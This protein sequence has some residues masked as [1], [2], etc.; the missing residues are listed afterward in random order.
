MWN[1]VLHV[2]PLIQEMYSIMQPPILDSYGNETSSQLTSQ[3]N[4]IVRKHLCEVHL[5]K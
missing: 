4:P 3:I 5:H 2:S 1:K